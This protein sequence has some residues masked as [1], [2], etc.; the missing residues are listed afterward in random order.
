M[1]C[2]GLIASGVIVLK[3]HLKSSIENLLRK[4]YESCVS[5]EESTRAQFL[6]TLLAESSRDARSFSSREL[7]FLAKGYLRP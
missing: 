1:R 6:T 5:A 4:H 7:L 2:T 3:I